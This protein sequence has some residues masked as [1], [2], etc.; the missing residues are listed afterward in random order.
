MAD[1]FTGL[2]GHSMTEDPLFRG[3]TIAAPGKDI[4]TVSYTPSGTT[5]AAT[6]PIKQVF[7]PKQYLEAM[8][9]TSASARK[10]KKWLSAL[11]YALQL[12]NPNFKPEQYLN[13]YEKDQLASAESQWEMLEDTNKKIVEQEAIK[14]MHDLDPD[15]PE[16]VGTLLD[17]FG[18]FGIDTRKRIMDDWQQFRPPEIDNTLLTSDV[19]TKGSRQRYLKSR[20]IQDLEMDE[21]LDLRGY[22]DIKQVRDVEKSF[23]GEYVKASQEFSGIVANYGRLLAS[24]DEDSGP[25]DLALIFN[26]MKMN[27]PGSTVREG[28]FS[29]AQNAPGITARIRN[30]YNQAIRGVRLRPEDRMQ[31]LETAEAMFRQNEATQQ[32]LITQY[33]GLAERA[34]VDAANVIIRYAP[35][36][37]QDDVEYI[38][39]G[40]YLVPADDAVKVMDH[41]ELKG[42]EW[43]AKEDDTD[44]LMNMAPEE[45]V[46][47]TRT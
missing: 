16:A 8:T 25:G 22:A 32:R 44:I 3:H 28:E 42:E 21:G 7:N 24:A 35:R 40:A 36:I 4:P 30:L 13:N 27:D 19:F 10:E 15:T 39:I 26:F 18:V 38:K 41:A 20:N 23:R 46:L 31:F 5:P 12:E 37:T 45:E 29:N 6:G 47:E 14:R 11:G 1:F 9:Q 2:G 17:D 43:D 34:N 33:S